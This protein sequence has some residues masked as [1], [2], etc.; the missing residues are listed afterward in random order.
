MH[1]IISI[2]EMADSLN[3]QFFL[4]PLVVGSLQERKEASD[5]LPTPPY[6]YLYI[7]LLIIFF[8]RLDSYELEFYG[9]QRLERDFNFD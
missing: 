2:A 7:Y 3:H 9:L 6:D 1:Q 5:T 4:P 8:A